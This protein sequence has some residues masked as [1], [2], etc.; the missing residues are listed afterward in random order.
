MKEDWSVP[1]IKGDVQ[2]MAI[3]LAPPVL[4][5]QKQRGAWEKLLDFFVSCQLNRYCY[6]A[7]MKWAHPSPVDITQVVRWPERKLAPFS[8]PFTMCGPQMHLWRIQ[9][10]CVGMSF[11][12][13]LVTH[14]GLTSSGP[15]HSVSVLDPQTPSCCICFNEHLH[16]V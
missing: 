15:T 7:N 6:E 2:Q 16:D 1:A 3:C 4:Q 11:A 13:R 9:T 14:Q 5:R 12:W 8:L 10:M